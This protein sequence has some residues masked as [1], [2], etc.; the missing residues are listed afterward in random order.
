[1]IL[2]PGQ[3]LSTGEQR[4]Y[5]VV[6][7][8][9]ETRRHTFY[10]ALKLFW[11]A[12]GEEHALYE[13]AEDE[14]LEVVVRCGRTAEPSN[15]TNRHCFERDAVLG[16][17]DAPWLPEALDVLD[18]PGSQPRGTAA[19]PLLVLAHPHGE[20]LVD[21]PPQPSALPRLI[22]FLQES[23][24]MLEY[25]RGHGLRAAVLEPEDFVI[26]SWGRWTFFGT[27]LVEP[28]S[29]G[30]L[31]AN[32]PVIWGGFAGRLLTGRPLDSSG[33]AM[34]KAASES[35]TARNRRELDALLAR[36]TVGLTGN[37]NDGDRAGA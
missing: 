31:L 16:L 14:W 13:A 33:V 8:A 28:R 23:L 26:D 20:R 10:R 25:F 22:R 6:G 34:L 12:R 1:M 24:E 29:E 15:R 5:Q 32:D 9:W 17:A 18:L 11:N 27:D 19:E 37:S 36:I 7:I 30:T 3:R 4:S 35:L 2:T 21:G